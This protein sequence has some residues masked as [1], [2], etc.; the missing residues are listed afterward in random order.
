MFRIGLL[1]ASW[2]APQ[3]VI[4]PASILPHAT[5]SAVAARSR[6]RVLGYA[7]RYGIDK[8]FDSYDALIADPKLDIIYISLP[9]SLHAY[10]SIK[11]LDA[12]KHV[13]CEKPTAM[14]LTE[15]QAMVAAAEQNGKRLFE[16]FHS[17]FHPSFA[18]CKDWISS[19]RI[20]TV[21]S[22]KAHF[23]VGLV[24]D[25]AKNQYRPELGGGCMMDMGCYPLHWA[26]QLLGSQIVSGD[27]KTTLSKSGVDDSMTA[28]L[29]L[30]GD[31]KAHLTAAMHP[32][33]VFDAFL[34]I[35]GTKG[36]I[37]FQNPLVPHQSGEL[38]TTIGNDVISAPISTVT[39]YCYQLAAMLDAIESGQELPVEA[40]GLLRQQSGLD[41]LYALAGLS[42]L[43]KSTYPPVN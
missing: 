3:A 37:R 15:A 43:R 19:G 8:A 25:G 10:W 29:I 31:V 9:P 23:G 18:A 39:T 5:I 30:E 42:H 28:D 22:I 40:Q 24:D 14:N 6:D 7:E 32:D 35:E 13:V 27:V 26:T 1:G 33:T 4:D 2:I 17:R 34:E 41:T 11:A 21:K 16:A 20:G 36:K 12:G 38:V